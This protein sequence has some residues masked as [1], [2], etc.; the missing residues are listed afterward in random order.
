MR[1]L[2]LVWSNLR[3]RKLRTALTALSVLVAFLLFGYLSAI[4]EAL[5]QG[6][7][8]AGA[9]RLIVRH[10]VSIVQPLPAFYGERVAHIPGVGL[11]THGTW[12]GGVYQRPTNFFP[13]FAVD[14]EAYLALYPEFRL[15]EKEKAAW[16]ATRSGAVVGRATAQRFGW[17]V[18]D[19]IPLQATVWQ[20]AAGGRNWE[21]DLVG[22][23]DGQDRAT[24]TSQ[25]LFHYQYL[26]EGRRFGKGLVGW[27]LVRVNDPA[28]ATAVAQRIDAEF[29]N[30]A[31]ETKAETEGAFVRA[32]AH[33][34]GN[35]GAIMV[36]V[37]SAVFFTMLLVAG[38]AIAQSVRERV[39]EIGVLKA[40]GY[41]DRQVL[42][43]VLA[44]SCAIVGLGGVA[45]LYV[46]TV[47]VSGGDP[48]GGALPLFHL[49]HS[50]LARGTVLVAA[51]GLAAGI[52]PAYRAMSLSV[53]ESLRRA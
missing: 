10:R 31:A 42:G 20:R 50:D 14:P 3:R 45:G 52:L 25:F 8:V 51:L 6:V 23:Y 11:A 7:N 24:D 37:L 4:E 5:S 35:V 15:P 2:P 39:R 46:A 49:P 30:S 21:F 53:A 18:G 22:I 47:A 44:E 26:E 33:Q 41:S 9:D 1:F 32:F 34:I 17:K 19:R 12:F 27:Y 43:L 36:A 13:Q 29:Q 40:M 16:L 38:N 28:Q 48:T